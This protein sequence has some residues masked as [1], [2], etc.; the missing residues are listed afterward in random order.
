[1]TPP[2]KPKPLTDGE[3]IDIEGILRTVEKIPNDNGEE[4]D[5]TTIQFLRVLEELKR[6][7]EGPSESDK[8]RL[9]SVLAGISAPWMKESDDMALQSLK[10]TATELAKSWG[11]G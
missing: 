3:L 1:M 2:E 6:L 8:K 11:V 7:R 4:N 5:W 9:R 10:W